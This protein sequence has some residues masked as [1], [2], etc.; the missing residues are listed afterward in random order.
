MTVRTFIQLSQLT[1]PCGCYGAVA[2]TLHPIPQ[3]G[4]RADMLCAFRALNGV[5]V[6]GPNL[7]PDGNIQG[8]FYFRRPYSI[9]LNPKSPH[10]PSDYRT[11]G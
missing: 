1:T 2:Y 10:Y 3:R 7:N 4:L 5:R 6:Y 11:F 9:N 8:H